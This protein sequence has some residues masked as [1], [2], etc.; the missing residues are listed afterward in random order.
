MLMKWEPFGNLRRRGNV[1]R[2]LAD[3][4]QEIEE[5][6]HDLNKAEL[7]IEELECELHYHHETEGD[8]VALNNENERLENE[9]TILVE[10][11][12]RLEKENEKLRKI[13][14]V[15]EL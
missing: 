2:E 3:M 6:E 9:I 10:E 1:F 12:K 13:K 15:E 8:V 4:Q 5:L 11:V 7:K 14:A